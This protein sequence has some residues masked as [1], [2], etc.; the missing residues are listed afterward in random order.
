MLL[1]STGHTFISYSRRDAEVMLR[2]VSYLRGEGLKIWIDNEKL[3]PGTPIWEREIEKAIDAAYAIVVVLSPDAKESIWVLNELTLA[4]EYK[5]RVFPVLVR[6]DF[7]D[8]IP[9]RLVTRQ[10][11]DLRTNE[12]RGLESLSVALSRYLEE[13]NRIDEECQAT[14]RELERQKQAELELIAAQKAEEEQLAK[15]KKEAERI[16]EEKRRTEE[17]EKQR[18]ATQKVEEERIAR[19]KLEADRL[20]E[21]KRLA[22]EAEKQRITTQKAEEERITK[23]KLE[24]ERLAKEKRIAEEAEKQR[25]TKAKLEEERPA[26]ENRTVEKAAEQ[27]IA[28]KTTEGEVLIG[29][30]PTDATQEVKQGILFTKPGFSYAKYGAIASGFI[31]LGFVIF[32]V[33]RSLTSPSL[34]PETKETSQSATNSSVS[35]EA[36]STST[37]TFTITPSKTPTITFTP[38]P[39]FTPIATQKIKSGTFLTTPFPSSTPVNDVDSISGKI[40]NGYG[41][42]IGNVSLYKSSC[43]DSPVSTTRTDDQGN[44]IFMDVPAGLY[45]IGIISCWSG[46]EKSQNKPLSKDFIIFTDYSLKITQPKDESVLD[47]TTPT[48]IWNAVPSAVIYQVNI[49]KKNGDGTSDWVEWWKTNSTSFTITTPL[50]DSTS[51]TVHIQ[52]YTDGFLPLIAGL[53]DFSIK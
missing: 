44:Y 24:A 28:S 21:E 22:E 37:L 5:K 35:L 53:V 19:A 34:S 3:V 26:K 14:K 52:A 42:Y 27:H 13:L 6:G 47:S 9:F 25:I 29:N 51:Y 15:A 48:I 46:I 16:A 1:P 8:S 23:I 41:P 4:D 40:Y 7:R 49:F 18:I 36:S 11:V 2:I 12:E 39:T 31:L 43:Y 32:S 20:T 30:I 33:F 10:F 17:A 38:S 50:K 45:K